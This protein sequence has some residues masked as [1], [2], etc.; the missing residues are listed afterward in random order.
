MHRSAAVPSRRRQ[1][2]LAIQPLIFWVATIGITATA[3]IGIYEAYLKYIVEPREPAAIKKL[4]DENQRLKAE[5][6]QLQEELW[7]QSQTEILAA[8]QLIESK[9]AIETNPDGVTREVRERLMPPEEIQLTRLRDALDRIGDTLR[10]DPGFMSANF[11]ASKI[12]SWRRHLP[13]YQGKVSG[14]IADYLKEHPGRLKYLT[15][16]DSPDKPDS[17]R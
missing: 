2:G 5:V 9:K 17:E 16:R 13:E 6:G 1:L 15:D 14:S 4:S 7:R 3:T 10:E 8:A 12:E 11:D